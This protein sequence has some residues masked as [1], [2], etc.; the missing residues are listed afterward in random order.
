[1]AVIVHQS[2]RGKKLIKIHF[3]FL[4][5]FPLKLIVSTLKKKKN[6][7]KNVQLKEVLF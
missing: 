1:M 5:Y 7:I 6:Q 3:F 2:A 4:P